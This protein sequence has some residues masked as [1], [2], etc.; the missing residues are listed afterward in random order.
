MAL[1]GR[2]G[3]LADKGIKEV[4]RR[5]MVAM[6]RSPRAVRYRYPVKVSGLADEDYL[7]LSCDWN[8]GLGVIEGCYQGLIRE[9]VTGRVMEHSNRRRLKR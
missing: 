1:K 8:G 5:E 9:S 6:G 7:L 4:L 3:G 2:Y